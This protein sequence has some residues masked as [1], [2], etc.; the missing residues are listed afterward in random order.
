M[1]IC[2]H[3]GLEK[4]DEIHVVASCQLGHYFF[5]PGC[6]VATD[7]TDGKPEFG[8]VLLI[9]SVMNTVHLV[10]KC[11]RTLE[12][13]EHYYAFNTEETPHVFVIPLS[14]LRISHPLACHIITRYKLF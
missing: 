3:F 14:N 10:V 12:F 1:S 8:K 5:K 6:F 11:S 9:I 13:D 2:S 4:Q 7:V